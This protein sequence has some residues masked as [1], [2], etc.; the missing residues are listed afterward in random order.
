MTAKLTAAETRKYMELVAKFP[1]ASIRSEKHLDAAT[2]T[3]NKLLKRAPLSSGEEQYLEALSDLV[4]VYEAEHHPV[5]DASGAEML[6]HLM[7]AKQVRQADVAKATGIAKSTIALI[8]AGKRRISQSHLP[9]LAEFFGVS[10][11]VFLPRVEGGG[12]GNGPRKA[13]G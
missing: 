3:I 2:A 10:P 12:R 8:L 4:M 11:A 1:L 5:P 9:K 7:D 6:E 13:A